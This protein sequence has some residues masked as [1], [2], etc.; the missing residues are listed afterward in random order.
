MPRSDE[1][2]VQAELE[3][4]DYVIKRKRFEI[5]TAQTCHFVVIAENTEHRLGE[6]AHKCEYH[7]S[8]ADC[9]QCAVKRGLFHTVHLVTT[10]ILRYHRRYRR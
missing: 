9:H 4:N 5:F 10:E 1:Q 7:G 3:R 8:Y 2:T 6:Y